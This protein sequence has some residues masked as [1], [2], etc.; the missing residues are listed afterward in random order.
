MLAAPCKRISTAALSPNSQM[1][2][3]SRSL[4]NHVVL[5]SSA[6]EDIG[7]EEAPAALEV[8]GAVSAASGGAREM[9]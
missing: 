8:R 3:F 7:A 2:A 1:I 5:V 4:V 9:V 6:L